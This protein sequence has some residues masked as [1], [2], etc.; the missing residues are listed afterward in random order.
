MAHIMRLLC[1]GY[2][3]E[4]H[5]LVSASS[6]HLSHVSSLESH[7]SSDFVYTTPS[8]GADFAEVLDQSV[9][10]TKTSS[11]SWF[12]IISGALFWYNQEDVKGSK[13]VSATQELHVS[14]DVE[15]VKESEARVYY[16]TC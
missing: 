12:K 5:H 13:V 10:D 3:I 7:C 15:L 8:A 6:W 1:R 14:R 2:F 16:P 4:Q 11:N 9:H